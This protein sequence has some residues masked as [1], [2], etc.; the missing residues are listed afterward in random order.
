ME[1]ITLAVSH[2][3][4]AAQWHPTRNGDLSPDKVPPGSGKLVWWLC[5]NDPTH[6]WRTRVNTRVNGHGCSI[7]A[8]KKRFDNPLSVTHPE[9]AAEWHPSKNGD[10]TP[11]QKTAGSSIEVWWKCKYGH[12]WPAKIN[13][14]ASKRA[15]EKG[16]GQCPYCQGKLPLSS[17]GSKYPKLAKQWHPTKNGSRT[18]FDVPANSRDLVWWQCETYPEHEWQAQI[19]SRVDS[20]GE[21]KFC[22]RARN[23]KKPYLSE[24]SL[25]LAMEWHRTKKWQLNSR[26]GKSGKFSKG[27]VDL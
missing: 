7:C 14:R 18:A 4:I 16:Y 5:P 17:F 25:E 12:E 6:V 15:I 21:C 24:F 11:E 26:Q 22:V 3:E 13:T 20:S 2:P 8:G 23:P 1:K 19:K 27:L 10:L 9:I